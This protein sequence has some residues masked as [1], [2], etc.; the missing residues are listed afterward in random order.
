LDVPDHSQLPWSL[1]DE[2]S[3]GSIE[4]MLLRAFTVW[5]LIL[6]LEVLHGV[7]RTLWLLPL[8]GDLPSRQI[9]VLVGS[10]LIL[11]V[12]WLTIG[13]IGARTRAQLLAV[14]GM[15]LALMLLAEIVLGRLVFGFAW[16]R[17]LEDFDVARGGLLGI[18]MAVLFAAPA[19]ALHF[20]RSLLHADTG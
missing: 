13:W 7:A 14:G 17:L 9:G 16:S 1:H 12:A 19:L 11:V 4:A 6:F 3:F 15:W 20:R 10:A 5:L 8:V 18:G 2:C